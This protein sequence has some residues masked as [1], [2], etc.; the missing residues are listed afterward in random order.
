MRRIGPRYRIRK[1]ALAVCFAAVIL[2]VVVIDLYPLWKRS[3]KI[4]M[5]DP[6][7]LLLPQTSRNKGRPLLPTSI[8]SNQTPL[9]MDKYVKFQNS[10]LKAPN[11]A[12]AL[13]GIKYTFQSRGRKRPPLLIWNCPTAGACG[14]LG[15]RLYGIIMGL[16]IAILS[17]RIFLIQEWNINGIAH[18][19][20]DY[21][22]PN[23]LWWHATVPSRESIDFGLLSTM[24]DRQ[25][26]LLLEPCGLK[27]DKRDYFLRNNIMTYES[28]LKESSCLQDYWQDLSSKREQDFDRPLAEVG[29]H[30]L[31]K[32]T[33]HVDDQ[34]TMLLQKSGTID[35]LDYVSS[36]YI[37]MHIRTGQG[38]TWNDP[39]RHSGAEN[40]ERFATCAN[41]M[42][43]SIAQKCETTPKVYIAADNNEAKKYMLN[44]YSSAGI[45]KGLTD[46]EILHIDRSNFDKFTSIKDAYDNVWGELKLLIDATCLVLSRSK[47][48]TLALELSAQQP[49]C[50]VFFDKCD[51]D[52]LQEAVQAI[53]C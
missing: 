48:S 29:F 42:H 20:L 38:E 15:D 21:L 40:L 12:G 35:E 14:G 7:G 52:T 36:P 16:Y 11:G 30:T 34:A 9:W 25:H 28:Q 53:S 5:K 43:R 47:I 27:P 50:A 46:L 39:E 8:V 19:L 23:H 44:K 3:D 37:G 4:S 18:P 31:F 22:Q 1:R 33:R 10:W 26:P 45:F 17:E 32:F 41:N 13:N 6:P 49:Q 24:D 51:D 2:A